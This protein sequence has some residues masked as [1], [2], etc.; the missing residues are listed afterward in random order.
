MC[1]HIREHPVIEH[2]AA[3]LI[4]AGLLTFGYSARQSPVV[5]AFGLSVLLGLMEVLQILFRD[6]RGLMILPLVR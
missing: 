3:Y 1:G 2:I 5:I 4:T 6:T